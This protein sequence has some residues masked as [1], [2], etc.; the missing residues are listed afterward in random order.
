MFIQLT[1]VEFVYRNGVQH[2]PSAQVK[3][4]IHVNVGSIVSISERTYGSCVR[5]VKGYYDVAEEAGAIFKLIDRD[6]Q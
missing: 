3:C 1:E 4:P 6:A 5:L 2:E